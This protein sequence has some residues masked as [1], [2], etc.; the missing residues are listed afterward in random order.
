MSMY[1]RY[2][3]ASISDRLK[4]PPFSTYA[5]QSS[6]HRQLIPRREILEYS[7]YH[8]R[9]SENTD[10]IQRMGMNNKIRAVEAKKRSKRTSP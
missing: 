9:A 2:R 5:S 8:P 4:M 10:Q 7:V 1:G 6:Y 3:S